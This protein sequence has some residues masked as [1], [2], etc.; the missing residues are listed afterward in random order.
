MDDLPMFSRNSGEKK[1]LTLPPVR[2]Q[3]WMKVDIRS[4]A[5]LKGISEADLIRTALEKY[6]D[7]EM[8]L[9]Q[10]LHSIFAGRERRSNDSCAL[11]CNAAIR[12]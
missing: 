4:L 7:E 6:I 1:F 10:G 12:E 3:E 9:Y 5:E 2:V 11:P 8:S